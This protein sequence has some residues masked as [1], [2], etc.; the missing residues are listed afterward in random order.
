MAAAP[1]NTDHLL[2]RSMRRE[3]GG[4]GTTSD[5]C[6]G[7]KAS[8]CVRGGGEQRK[9]EMKTQWDA[10]KKGRVCVCVCECVSV[11]PGWPKLTARALT[12]F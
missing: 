1:D 8:V 7:F 3:D 4:R 9:H 2:K 12:P 10:A 11:T 6:G 5:T